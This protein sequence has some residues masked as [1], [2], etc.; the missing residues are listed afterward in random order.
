M[1]PAHRDNKITTDPSGC[2]S[3]GRQKTLC[4]VFS[5]RCTGCGSTLSAPNV[6][7]VKTVRALIRQLFDKLQFHVQRGF[8]IKPAELSNIEKFVSIFS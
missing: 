1:L 6:S 3:A 2:Q 4:S 5:E 7:A 8:D